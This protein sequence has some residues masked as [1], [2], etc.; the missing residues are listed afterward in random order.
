MNDSFIQ[1]IYF[2]STDDDFLQ[3]LENRLN[4]G[5]YITDIESSELGT[6]SVFEKSSIV[7]NI[8]ATTSRNGFL[9]DGYLGDYTDV[10]EIKTE[11]FDL[12]D[13]EHF[14]SPNNDDEGYWFTISEVSD[15]E[16]FSENPIFNFDDFCFF[17]ETSEELNKNGL[18]LTDVEYGDGIWFASYGQ[19]LGHKIDYNTNFGDFLDQL[20]ENYEAGFPL[21]NIEHGDGVWFGIYE[22]EESLIVDN[23]TYNIEPDINVFFEIAQE[24]MSENNYL[25]DIEYGNGI[26]FGIFGQGI[27]DQS[28]LQDSYDL[29]YAYSREAF[30]IGGFSDFVT[31]DPFRSF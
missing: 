15:E 11:R 26:W 30:E 4:Q 8:N 27:S 19:D 28:I 17:V 31:D 2:S 3:L 18:A 20:G 9:V 1:G 25:L 21:T 24:K 13:F 16:D 12:I 6:F 22:N 10:P 7:T 23:I 14:E 29:S 5:F